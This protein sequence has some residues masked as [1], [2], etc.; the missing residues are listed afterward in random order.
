MAASALLRPSLTAASKQAW[1]KAFGSL[2]VLHQ[3]AA[4]DALAK[5]PAHLAHRVN[6]SHPAVSN[7]SVS[8]RATVTCSLLPG[9]G[10]GSRTAA[11]SNTKRL[12][13][14]HSPGAYELPTKL[15]AASELQE[16]SE[17][18][19]AGMQACAQPCGNHSFKHFC[20][21]VYIVI[22]MVARFSC[23]AEGTLKSFRWLPFTGYCNNRSWL[24]QTK[25]L[26]CVQRLTD[27]H[28][29]AW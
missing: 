20:A 28:S 25:L 13:A 18:R 6:H 4:V 12:V 3:P 11:T 5:R 19:T 17:H 21:C 8:A 2:R 15:Y 22:C 7:T 10:S 23:W 26:C 14:Q 29:L 9:W 24:E 27:T 16:R 1:S